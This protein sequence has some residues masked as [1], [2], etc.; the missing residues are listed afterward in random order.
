MN[1]VA[2]RGD[3]VS[4]VIDGRYPLLEWLG[5]SGTSGTFLT[6]LDGL[7]SHKAAIK[8]LPSSPQSEDRLSGWA[9][10]AKLSHP[11]LVHIHHHGRADVNGT[12]CV[13]IVCD[14]AEELLSQIIPERPL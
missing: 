6:E 11:H 2:V 4:Q 8:L 13:Y 10:V 14:L 12:Q 5:G 1:A 3:W 7:G 9:A